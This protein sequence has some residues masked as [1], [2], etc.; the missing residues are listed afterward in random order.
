M[1]ARTLMHTDLLQNNQLISFRRK[2]VW[3]GDDGKELIP[4]SQVKTRQ[5]GS[6]QSIAGQLTSTGSLVKC[7]S[8]I[9][10]GPNIQSVDYPGHMLLLLCHLAGCL[11]P[12]LLMG[13]NSKNTSL[14]AK[15]LKIYL[16]FCHL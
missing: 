6:M 16:H 14:S 9:I 11:L 13:K 4:V 15:K 8:V 3:W 1:H 7:S 10:Q 12:F 5:W 2:E